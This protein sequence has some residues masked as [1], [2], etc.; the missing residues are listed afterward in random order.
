MRV[1]QVLAVSTF[2]FL[3]AIAAAQDSNARHREKSPEVGD[4]SRII[5]RTSE[6]IGSRIQSGRIC[7]TADEWAAA[8]RDS[9]NRVEEEQQRRPSQ[10]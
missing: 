7:M 1:L 4:G 2:V 10:Y 5:C 9:R 8:K 6:V 3:P